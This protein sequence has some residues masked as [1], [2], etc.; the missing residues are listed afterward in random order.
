MNGIAARLD[1]LGVTYD[2]REEESGIDLRARMTGEHGRYTTWFSLDRFRDDLPSLDIRSYAPLSG[3]RSNRIPAAAIESGRL[4]QLHVL[5]NLFNATELRVGALWLDL[6]DSD[7]T[8]SW[9]LPLFAPPT[10]VAVD[11]ALAMADVIDDVIPC[12]REVVLEGKT[13]WDALMAHRVR[14]KAR[15][16]AKASPPGDDSSEIT[17]APLPD[18]DGW[19]DDTDAGST[20]FRRAV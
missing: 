2:R 8:F 13:A 7:I 14:R 1:E 4:A 12:A 16:A 6:D 11:F 3:V 15:D 17:P 5:I 18:P 9:T 20:P 10:T 19:D